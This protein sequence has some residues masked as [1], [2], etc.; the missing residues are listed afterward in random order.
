[1]KRGIT[2]GVF[3]C[4]HYGHINLFIECSKLCDFLSVAVQDDINVII[5]KPK[6][7]LVNNLNQRMI[8]ISEIKCVDQVIEYS[9]IDSIISK[10]D[11]DILF[12]GPDQNNQHFID[13][14]EWCQNNNK[15][16][17]VVNRTPNVSSTLLRDKKT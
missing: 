15:E 13:A 8:L 17:V 3:D 12:V 1:M 10:I 9:Q 16:I 7:I 6:A 11:F 5:N 14:V 4:L 2:F